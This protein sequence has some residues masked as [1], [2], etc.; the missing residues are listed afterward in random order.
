[1]AKCS[2][3]LRNS[4]NLPLHNL[5]WAIIWSADSTHPDDEGGYCDGGLDRLPPR[6]GAKH[7]AVVVEGGSEGPWL[8]KG[9]LVGFQY[10]RRKG[11][12]VAHP[13]CV[14]VCV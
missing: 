12:P 5:E 10:V 7:A 9:E 13:L 11:G 4:D 14:C 3:T 1:M 8:G 6:P 2:M